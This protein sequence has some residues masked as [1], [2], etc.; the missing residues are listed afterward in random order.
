MNNISAHKINCTGCKACYNSCPCSAIKMERINGGFLAPQVQKA[1]IDCGVCVKNCPDINNTKPQNDFTPLIYAMKNN[2]ETELKVSSSGGVFL[3]AASYVIN[4]L[5]GV[6]FGAAYCDDF[7]VKIIKAESTEELYRLA[8]SK[9]VYADTDY[10]YREVKRL[11][12]L[13]KTVLYSGVSC[14]IAALISFLGKKY[15]NLICVEILCHG[16]PS[17]ELFDKY[18]DVVERRANKKIKSIN[19]RDKTKPWNPL[20]TK[21]VRLEFNDSKKTIRPEDFD[22]YMSLYV[23]EI[24]YRDTCYTCKYVGMARYGDIVIGD[25]GGLGIL[26]ECKLDTSGGVS[27]VIVNSSNGKRVISA[28][29]DV[30]Y[31]ERELDEVVV[32]NSCLSH[33]IKAPQ[34]HYDFI[35]DYENLS[36]EKLFDKYYYKNFSYL[37]RATVKKMAFV[38]LGHKTVAKLLFKN[39]K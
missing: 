5:N 33:N 36:D 28:L 16:A 15:D 38:L 32:L 21:S 37:L 4:Q 10:T 13:G 7:K 6:V 23:R 9:Y 39:K 25:F 3:K 35:K 2:H 18:I 11:L 19:Q 14:Q 27:L 20:I 12:N 24:P 17:Q 8:G 30:S 34:T 1:C 29:R 26:K 22:P 31:E